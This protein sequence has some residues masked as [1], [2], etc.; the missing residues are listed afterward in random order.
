MN[1][2]R[3]LCLLVLLPPVNSFD[4]NFL[5][6]LIFYTSS[7][8]KQQALDIGSGHPRAIPAPF[9]CDSLWQPMAALTVL[10]Q[11]KVLR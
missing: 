10:T 11:A 2:V 7:T 1:E 8:R 3:R 9:Q 4:G 6:I 5:R